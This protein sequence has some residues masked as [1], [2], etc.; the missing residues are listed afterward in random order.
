MEHRWRD[1]Y[2]GVSRTN[3]VLDFLKLAQEGPD[4]LT[5]KRAREIEGEA[6]FLRAWYHF[7]A[8]RIWENIPYI[9][10]VEEIGMIPE[11]VPNDSPGWDDIEN[12]LQFAIDN[13][14]GGP[15][16]EEVGRADRWA[17]MSVKAHVH[18]F[19][20]ELDQAKALLDEIILNGGFQLV[21][22]YMENYYLTTENNAESIFEIQVSTT[23]ED[24]GALNAN[25][26]G[27]PRA[28]APYAP[29]GPTG[30]GFYQ[31]SEDLF[32]AFQTTPEG[33]P[34]LE[35]ADRDPLEN[36]M[37]ISSS[38]TFV[39]TDHP[40]DPRVDW[41]IVRRGIPNQG[42]GVFTGNSQVREQP[43]GG[44]YYTKKFVGSVDEPATADGRNTRNVRA[45]RY[46]HILLWRAEI[47]VEEGDLDYARELVNMIRNRAK[48]SEYVKGRVTKYELDTQPS[49]SEIDYDQDAANYIIS[50]YPADADAFSTQENARKAVR[51]EH[52]LEFATEGLRFFQ[53]RRWGIDSQVL[54]DYITAD[55]QFRIFL[56]G[57]TYEPERD[58]YFPLPQSQLDIQPSLTQDPAY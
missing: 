24:G 22:N 5:E 1:C 49:E 6:K 50:E 14:G 17:A 19:Q 36:D 20:N 23:S 7:K 11:E 2:N 15:T 38:G 21:T 3:D 30:W 10:T 8:N 41:T 18:L 53:L 57:A 43:N 48:D 9:K 56:Q 27:L 58:D 45:Y 40:L 52:R 28:A 34:V 44:P 32:E 47:A 13:L 37:G 55:S 4:P 25:M 31:P 39:P 54:N 16:N 35:R 33:L 29:P 26:I 42:W 51:L 46:S 12:D